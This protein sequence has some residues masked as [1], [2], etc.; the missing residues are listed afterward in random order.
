MALTRNTIEYP[1]RFTILRIVL[2]LQSSLALSN[3]DCQNIKCKL[4][5][6]SFCK[7]KKK[8]RKKECLPYKC[9]LLELIIYCHSRFSPSLPPLQFPFSFLFLPFVFAFLLPLSYYA[10]LFCHLLS[11]V[12]FFQLAACETWGGCPI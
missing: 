5:R 2:S 9:N 8:E 11:F 1:S 3:K 6:H 7:K 4:H 12:T 10:L